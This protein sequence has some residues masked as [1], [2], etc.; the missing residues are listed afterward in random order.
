MYKA[1]LTTLNSDRL[2]YLREHVQAGKF[3]FAQIEKKEINPLLK[4]ISARC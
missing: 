4:F 1:S 2:R 3:N